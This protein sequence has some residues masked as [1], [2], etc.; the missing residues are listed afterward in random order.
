MEPATDSSRR[1]IWPLLLLTC[2]LLPACNGPA[3]GLLAWSPDKR[4]DDVTVNHAW[5]DPALRAAAQS[6]GAEVYTAHCASCHGDDLK[7]ASGSHASN[8]ADD[9]WLFGGEDM[10][11]FKVRPADVESSIRFGIRAG[12]PKGRLASNMPGWQDENSPTHSLSET[13]R[14]DVTLYVLSLVGQRTQ[15]AA[16]QRG[17]EL[18]NGKGACFDCHADDSKGDSSIGATDLT[19]S[20]IWLYGTSEAEVR[21]GLAQGHAGVSPAFEGTLTSS[22]IKAV[23]IYVYGRASGYDF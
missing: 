15:A 16:V 6:E 17:R 23:T 14:D 11:S 21:A 19:R 18:F 3:K 22:Q 1:K 13:E 5:E 9:H 12:H 7:G 4:L 20:T 2:G 8:L 10:E